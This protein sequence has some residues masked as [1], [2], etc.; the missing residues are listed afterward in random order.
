MKRFIVT[1]EQLNDFIERKKSKKIYEE[2]LLK[3][4][5]NMKFLTESISQENINQNII[6]DYKRKN[7]ITPYVFELL[8]NNKIIDDSYKII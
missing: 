7:K 1:E 5:R 8:I 2:I 6:D 3:I 4:N